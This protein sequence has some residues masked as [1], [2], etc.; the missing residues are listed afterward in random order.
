MKCRRSPAELPS[1]GMPLRRENKLISCKQWQISWHDGNSTAAVKIECTLS[2]GQT[3]SDMTISISAHKSQAAVWSSRLSVFA[4]FLIVAAL[5]L[6]RFAGYPT[7]LL[8]NTLLVGFA[9]AACAFLLGLFAIAV[10]WRKGL[11]GGTST[12]FGIIFSLLVFAWPLSI[13]PTLLELPMINDVTTDPA[14]PPQYHRAAELRGLGANS[15]IY[16]GEAASKAQSEAYP[17]VH[18]ILINRSLA[19]AYELAMSSAKR[20]GWKIIAATPPKGAGASTAVI[21]ATDK[22]LLL[23]FVDDAVIR[24]T[25]NN[26]SARI[27]L[28][29]SSRHGRHD[30]G[31]NAA[32]IEAFAKMFQARVQATVAIAAERAASR[33]RKA[34]QAK[35]KTRTQRR[36]SRRS[37]KRRRRRRR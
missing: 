9:I 36:S 35:R 28:R 25:G 23:G 19:E 4:I 13:I 21:E 34:A 26:E 24:I 29:S 2:R 30:F 3:L 12:A 5:L 32:R 27:D 11:R 16:P 1:Q 18:P 14:N 33:A 8:L 7:G 10:I 22:T 17:T 20:L 15:T 37:R 31:K 6:H